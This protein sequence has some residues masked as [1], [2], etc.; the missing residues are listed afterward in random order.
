MSPPSL[1]TVIRGKEAFLLKINDRKIIHFSFYKRMK[2]K[3]K[4]KKWVKENTAKIIVLI[5]LVGLS[6]VLYFFIYELFSII[7]NKM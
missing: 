2:K 6:F 5:Y 3:K 7:K 4:R 1:N